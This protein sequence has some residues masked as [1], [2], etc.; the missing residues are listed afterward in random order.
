MLHLKR[1]KKLGNAR[2]KFD[3]VMLKDPEVAE[4]FQAMIG[5]TFAALTILDADGIDVETLID[6][7]NTAVTNTASEILGK[8]R[9][10][11][12]QLTYLQSSSSLHVTTYNHNVLQKVNKNMQT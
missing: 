5:G 4:A 10:P 12:S 1:V 2:I 11:G 6:T 8:S 9:S 7:F 3:L